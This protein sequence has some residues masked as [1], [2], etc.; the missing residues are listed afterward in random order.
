MQQQRFEPTLLNYFLQRQVTIKCELDLTAHGKLVHYRLANRKNHK[1]MLLI[2]KSSDGY[3]IV[4]CW[5]ALGMREG[6]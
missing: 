2:L 1:P 3:V 6:D 4:R 5:Y